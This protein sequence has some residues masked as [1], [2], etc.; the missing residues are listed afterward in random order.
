[1]SMS[2][3]SC[4]YEPY[5]ILKLKRNSS[6]SHFI[7]VELDLSKLGFMN[8]WNFPQQC[9]LRMDNVSLLDAAIS[10]VKG[11]VNVEEV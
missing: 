8:I 7:G 3:K 6:K 2:V 11:A 4:G 10:L 9:L 5:S 1:M